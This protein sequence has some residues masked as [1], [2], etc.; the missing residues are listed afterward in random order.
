VPPADASGVATVV[1]SWGD[2][3]SNRIRVTTSTH[4]YLR[5]GRYTIKLTITD[6]AGNRTVL[7]KQIRITTKSAGHPKKKTK[8]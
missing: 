4:R 3:T 2:R 6:R 5:A 1:V 8:K 7:S